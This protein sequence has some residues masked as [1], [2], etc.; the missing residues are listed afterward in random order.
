MAAERVID[1]SQLEDLMDDPANA[2]LLKLV[3]RFALAEKR[4]FRGREI[5][6]GLVLAAVKGMSQAALRA[7]PAGDRAAVFEGLHVGLDWFEEFLAG[8]GAAPEGEA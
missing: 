3:E 2:D 6:P 5:D 8:I 4:H 1:V 7:V